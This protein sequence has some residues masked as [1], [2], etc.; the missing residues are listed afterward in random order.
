MAAAGTE[1]TD[2]D[3]LQLAS[4]NIRMG[5]AFAIVLVFVVGLGRETVG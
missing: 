1:E 5:L 4:D 3:R 2:D